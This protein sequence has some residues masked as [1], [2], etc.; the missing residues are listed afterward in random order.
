LTKTCPSGSAPIAD[1]SHRL[2]YSPDVRTT[3][4]I[5]ALIAIMVTAI[6][7]NFI[8]GWAGEIVFFPDHS[9]LQSGEWL[10]WLFWVVLMYGPPVFAAWMILK[11]YRNDG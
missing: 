3:W 4:L 1:I 6:I 7:W 2:Q 10:S 8:A 9:L 11:A 5:F